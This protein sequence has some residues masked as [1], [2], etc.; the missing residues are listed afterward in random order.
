MET[1]TVR[2]LNKTK[3][4]PKVVADKFNKILSTSVK[5]KDEL[6]ETFTFEFNMNFQASIKIFRGEKPFI[7]ATLLKRTKGNKWEEVS[8]EQSLSPFLR[9]YQFSHLDNLF[10]ATIKV[11]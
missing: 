3:R 5:V 10:I 1:N 9:D 2:E 11:C 6:V 8:K 7:E 4:I